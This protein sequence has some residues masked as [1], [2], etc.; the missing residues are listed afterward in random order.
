MANE[1]RYVMKKAERP[2]HKK[3]QRHVWWWAVRTNGVRVS[4]DDV[5]WTYKDADA[6]SAAL[7]RMKSLR[8]QE[9]ADQ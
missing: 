9:R 5:G 2:N 3:G 8:E 7:R 1:Y 4:R 6:M